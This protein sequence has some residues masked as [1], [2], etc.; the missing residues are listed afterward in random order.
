MVEIVGARTQLRRSGAAGPAAA[1]STT[2]GRRASRS[3]PRRSCT[4][5]SAA[6]KGGDVIT[7][8]QETEG[9]DF[10]GRSSGWPTATGSRSSTR[11]PR[12]RRRGAAAAGRGCC[13]C[14]STP[15]VFYERTSG[16]P[17]RASRCA[18]TWP[19]A[20]SARRRVPR[21]P[22]RPLAGRRRPAAEG[23][24]E[25]LLA[26]RAGRRRARQPAR[27]RL[28]RRP[29][30]LPA[31]RRARARARLRR[32]PPAR[33]GPDH[34]QVRQLARERALPQ[35]LDRLRPRPCPQRDREGGPCALVVEGYTDVLAL[36][37]AGLGPA[38]ASMGTALTE[39]AA[40]GAP[41]A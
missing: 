31:R 2:S 9:L 37:Q 25:G 23:A 6:G 35:G 19:S 14:S 20:G 24:G 22:A 34:G 10:V 28:L 3:T 7:F 26:G 16:S 38:V 4:T 18:R 29:A 15:R 27:E 32:A 39:R 33:G 17:P 40:Q 41:P 1:R 11:R 21:V 13:R 12:R 8:V 30:G 5:A 36:H